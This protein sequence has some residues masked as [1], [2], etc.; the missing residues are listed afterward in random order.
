MKTLSSLLGINLHKVDC[1]ECGS[2]QPYFRKPKTWKQALWGGYTC[3]N[4]GIEL[5]KFGKKTS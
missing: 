1:S 4:C 5:D 3:S 2:S